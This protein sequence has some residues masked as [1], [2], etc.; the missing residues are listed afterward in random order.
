MDQA[1]ENKETT[2]SEQGTRELTSGPSLSAVCSGRAKKSSLGLS[3]AATGST[4]NPHAERYG[5][6]YKVLSQH[7]L[8]TPP[9]A[10][11]MVS[12]RSQGT[13]M[14]GKSTARVSR[15]RSRTYI[16]SSYFKRR[17][18]ALRF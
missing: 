1:L 11:R 7:A 15:P 14:V 2:N 5:G 10:G 4:L 13:A 3:G 12:N 18:S 17:A 16:V 6:P 9:A 8:Y